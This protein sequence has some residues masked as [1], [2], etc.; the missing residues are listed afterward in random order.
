[1]YWWDLDV[2]PTFTNGA[3]TGVSDVPLRVVSTVGGTIPHPKMTTAQRTAI[4]GLIEGI[5]VYDTDI[6]KPYWYNGTSWISYITRSTSSI[7]GT[8]AIGS[9]T[10]IDYTYFCNGTFP[11]TQPT[12]V[13]NTN[14]YTYRNTGSGSITLNPTG[15]ETINGASS[16]VVLSGNSVDLRSD[17]TGWW[18]V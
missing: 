5:G 4:T 1:M 17:G 13:S 12:A 11:L 2:A 3:F 9:T 6:H 15:A 14:R 7:T 16:L 18:T 10:F 8:T